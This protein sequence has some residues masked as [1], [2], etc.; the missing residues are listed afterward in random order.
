[1]GEAGFMGFPDWVMSWGS[2]GR[3]SQPWAFAALNKLEKGQG[4]DYPTSHLTHRLS[5]TA[6]TRGRLT[7]KF[8][9]FSDATSGGATQASSGPKVA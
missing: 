7:Q 9:T 5:Q 2:T 8:S 6:L 3:G 4:S 1:M